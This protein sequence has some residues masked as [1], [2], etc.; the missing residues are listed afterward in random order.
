[1]IE[2]GRVADNRSRVGE[3]EEKLRVVVGQ[4]RSFADL[5]HVMPDGQTE[6]PHRVEKRVQEPLIGRG[7]RPGKEHQDV[8]VG[9]ETQRPP[10]VA[11]ER[12]HGNWLTARARFG[13]ELLDERVHAM[14][15]LAQGVPAPLAAL[16]GRSEL[17][18]RGI[19]AA[20]DRARIGTDIDGR[21]LRL[22]HQAR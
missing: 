13:I 15:V 7:D 1:M 14:R 16:A 2:E 6:I 12:E 9:M 20:S 11:A 18:P 3:R 21:C 19:D 5:A 22:R 8:D 17:A 4:P 10:P